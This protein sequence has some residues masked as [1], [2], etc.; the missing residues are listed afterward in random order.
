M[1]VVVDTCVGGRKKQGLGQ[2]KLNQV[3]QGKTSGKI[4]RVPNLAAVSF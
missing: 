4:Q 3:W 1:K 2:N